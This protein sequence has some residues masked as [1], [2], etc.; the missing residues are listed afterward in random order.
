MTYCSKCGTEINDGAKFCPKCGTNVEVISREASPKEGR[1]IIKWFVLFAVLAVLAI[2]GW[3][4]WNNQKKDYSLEGLAKVV[5]NYDYIENFYDGMARVVKGDKCG[6]IDKMG[7]EIVPCIYDV[8]EMEANPNYSDG[9]ALVYKDNELFY[10]NKKGEKAFPFDYE[11]TYGFSEGYAIVSK[12]D[13][14]GFIDTNGKEIVPCIY[15]YANSYSDGMAAVIKGDKYGYIDTKGNVAIPISFK[16]TGEP[17][18]G[19]FHEGLAQLEVNGRTGFIDK[20]GKEVIPCKYDYAY[21][22][23][24]GL[25]VI[26][27]GDKFG[28][29]DNKGNEVIPCEY[30]TADSFTDG[31]AIVKKGGKYMVID[32]SGKVVFTNSYDI[33]R[34]K[35][36]LAR[37]SKPNSNDILHGFIDGKGKEIIPCI[38]ETWNDFSEGLV[39]VSKDGINGYVDKFGKSTFDVTSQE[40]LAQ[41]KEKKRIEQIK[42]EEEEKRIA[43][44]QRVEEERRRGVEKIVTLSFTRPE[45]GWDR[46]LSYSGNYGAIMTARPNQYVVTEYIQIPNGKV[47]IYERFKRT[48]G[49]P[50]LVSLWYYSRESGALKNRLGSYDS[51][52]RLKEGGLPILRPGDGFRISFVP[53]YNEGTKSIEVYFKEKDEDLVYNEEES[54]INHNVDITP[55][56]LECQTEITA[57]QR[58]IEDACRTF[59]V[60]GSQDVDMYKYTQM[61][62]TFLNGVSNLERKADKAFDKCARQLKE[63]GY[64]E[65]VSKIDEEKRSFHSAIYGLTT[66]TTQ[67]VYMSY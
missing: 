53:F 40:V 16:T 58:E 62:S 41:I 60:L 23:S 17:E 3:F 33:S 20:N 66:R 7:N 28:F 27:K 14:Y 9:L 36:G 34:F 48:E 26:M 18:Y 35:E 52:Y 30:E 11:W 5:T 44:E 65:A 22:F 59:A 42:R 13:K 15:D 54:N 29:V 43:E 55:I 1:K 49:D 50:D 12:N 8:L 64:P 21:D 45:Q 56:L 63:A 24:E 31:L 25:A 32:K 51:E 61:K 47:W 19:S 37:F 6:F 39:A 38:Y 67:Q 2:G 57:I 10:I 4:V 46:N